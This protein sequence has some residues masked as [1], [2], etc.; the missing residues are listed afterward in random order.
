MDNIM[1]IQ[2]KKIKLFI[3]ANSRYF[4]KIIDENKLA[5]IWITLYAKSYRDR[6]DFFKFNR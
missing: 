5:Y 3:L 6:V 4:K 1:H 2:I